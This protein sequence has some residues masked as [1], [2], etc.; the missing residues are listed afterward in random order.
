[1]KYSALLLVALFVTGCATD[2]MQTTLDTMS[3]MGEVLG[4]K[5]GNEAKLSDFRQ[6]RDATQKMLDEQKA[7]EKR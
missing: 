5:K 1:M 2:S 4:T 3:A 6:Q 7:R